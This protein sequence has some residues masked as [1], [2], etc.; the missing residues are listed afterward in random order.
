MKKVDD[1]IFVINAIPKEVCEELI[2]ECNTKK[3]KK[4]SW[5]NYETGTYHSEPTKELDVMACTQEQQNKIT[6][7]LTKAL[8]EYQFKSSK[9]NTSQTHT[10]VHCPD[11]GSNEE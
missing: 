5:N 8:E 1:Y 4:H 10:P 3:W 6:P 11:E 9:N 2:D 7:H